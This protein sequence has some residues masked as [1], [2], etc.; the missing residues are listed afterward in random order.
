M[1]R[2]MKAP[3]LTAVILLGAGANAFAT[4]NGL[5]S[6]PLGVN[7]V[8]DAILPAPGETQFF[9]YTTYYA[10]NRLAGPNG[11]SAVPNFKA[12]VFVD[13]PRILHTWGKTMGPFTLTSGI[14][15]PIVH[16]ETSVPVGSDSRW[17]F[18]DVVVHAMTVGYANESH[19]FFGALAVDFALPTGSFSSGRIA[20]TGLNS[21]AFMPNVNVTLF[22][23]QN[24]EF[25][26]TAGYEINSPNRAD[27]YHS[28]NVTFFDWGAG[29]SV[30]PRLQL[31]VQG[32]ALQQTT[33]DTLNG[34]TVNNG[35]RGRVF[36]IGP[37]VRFDIT[38]SSGIV[39]K[40]QHE[41]GARNR[42]EGNKLW[43]E[44]TF[45]LKG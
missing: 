45:P 38:P 13:S 30:L 43:V 6:Y 7:T 25:S 36:A 23:F 32:Y 33:D 39:L 28:G 24:A 20:N 40:W 27:G 26:A 35:F 29:Y 22:P 3:L 9:N 34:S 37:Q 31:G 16:S 42:P 14:V 44:L 41:F 12:N 5:Q 1:L 10:A 8:L 17:G 15:V 19:T 11:G 4:E 2:K 18:G 21:Y